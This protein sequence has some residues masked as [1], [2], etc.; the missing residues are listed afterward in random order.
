MLVNMDINTKS[1]DAIKHLFRKELDDGYTLVSTHP[2]HD[3]DGNVIY[4]RPRLTHETKEK[5][6][7]PVYCNHES[8]FKFGEPES[9]KI[10]RGLK[11]LYNLHLLSRFPKAAV[12][13]VEGEYVADQL[14]KFFSVNSDQTK[15]IAITSGGSTSADTADWSLL[16]DR[17]CIVWGDN[18]KPG[19]QYVHTLKS[20]LEQLVGALKV[21]EIDLLGL[22]EGGDFVD[23]HQQNPQATISDLE[24]LQMGSVDAVNHNKQELVGISLEDLLN[25]KL[26][27]RE[28]LL[29]PWLPSSGVCM[30]HAYRGVGKTYFALEVAVAVA[31]GGCFLGFKASKSSSVLFIDGEMPAVVM[32]ERLKQILSRI[33]CEVRGLQL[34]IITPDLQ[35]GFMPNLSSEEGQKMIEK[36]VYDADL[37]IVDNIATLC[38]FGKENE[39]DSWRPMQAWALK[40]RRLGKSVLFVHHSGKNGSQ[41]G[42]SGRED[43]QDTVINLKHPSGYNASM[44]AC[45]EIHFEKARGIFGD[46]AI[47]IRCQLTDAGWQYV[48]IEEAGNYQRVV[49]LMNAGCQQKDIVKELELSKGQVSK[50]VKKA[51]AKGDLE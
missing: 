15:H 25:L 50:L 5:I 41:R 8:K 11:P 45:F 16:K 3:L 22:V 43:I 49:E 14:N 29:S 42:T 47:P 38:S 4:Y 32:Q 34:K 48:V 33:G 27:K 30:V 40:L 37:I 44:G 17:E 21:I 31:T 9:L 19:N 20:K 36:L 23:W 39:I 35:D 7:R 1:Q 24:S 12:F 51:K 2:Y 28:Y 13:I 6:I 26:N 46:D 18:D 10:N